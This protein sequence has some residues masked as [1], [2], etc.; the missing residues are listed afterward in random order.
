[1]LMLTRR[2]G[3]VLYLDMPDGHGR[4]EI[5][6]AG[7]RGNVAQLGITAPKTVSITRAE[8]ENPSTGVAPAGLPPRR[9]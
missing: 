6:L 4:I 8:L 1:M 3:D 2:I 5:H 7:I 9:R